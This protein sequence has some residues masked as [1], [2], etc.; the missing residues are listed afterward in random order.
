MAMDHVFVSKQALKYGDCAL[1]SLIL[2]NKV[3]FVLCAAKLDC[4]GLPSS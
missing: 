2:G 3:E 4:V 1:R